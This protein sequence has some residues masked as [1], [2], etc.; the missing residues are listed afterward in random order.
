[1]DG[2]KNKQF[3]PAATTTTGAASAAVNRRA[4]ENN[5]ASE[6]SERERL[7][8]ERIDKLE[9]RLAELESRSAVKPANESVQ[10]VLATTGT[11]SPMA[12]AK[13]MIRKWKRPLRRPG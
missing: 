5:K 6:P 3:D 13:Q 4:S 2:K 10:P 12:S 9:Q 8:L 7:L 1:M 11:A